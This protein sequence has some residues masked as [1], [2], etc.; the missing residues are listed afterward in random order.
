MKFFIYYLFI[1]YNIFAFNEDL[2]HIKIEQQNSKIGNVIQ[3]STMF[4][5]DFFNDD[6]SFL[7]NGQKNY[8][9]SF[10]IKISHHQLEHSKEFYNYFK[11]RVYESQSQEKTIIEKIFKEENSQNENI[12]IFNCYEKLSNNTITPIYYNIFYRIKKYVYI[13]RLAKKQDSLNLF[14]YLKNNNL[15]NTQ[16]ISFI[17]MLIPLL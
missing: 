17:E 14:N 1:F 7:L 13:I 15:L 5:E 16:E 4:P 9:N 6:Y 2:Y 11:L 12:F 3:Y 8:L 10:L